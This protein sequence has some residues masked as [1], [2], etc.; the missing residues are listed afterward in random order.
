MSQENSAVHPIF[1]IFRIF[2]FIFALL[3]I[4]VLALPIGFYGMAMYIE[5]TLPNVDELKTMP[6]EMPLQIY[7]SDH[8]LIG[9]YGTRYSLPVT[10]GELPEPLI[11]A[12]LAAEDDTFFEHSGISV[13][14]LGRAIMQMM[15]HSS[16][17]TGGSSITQ[18]VAKNYFLT[19]EQTFERKL[20]EMYLARKIENE[21]TKDEIMTLY[22]N[23]IYLGQSAYGI[24]AGAR[25]Y[26]SKSLENLTI[27][28]MAMLAGLPK[29][30]SDFNPVINPDRALERRNWIIGRM[31]SEGFIDQ[32]QHDEAVSAPIGLNMYQERLDIN[33]P[34]VAEMTKDALVQKYGEAVM[35]SGWRV[36]LTIDSK[37]QLLAEEALQNGL[38]AYHRRHGSGWGGIAA[39]SGNLKN[40]L[41]IGTNIPA[42]VTAIH[43]RSIKVRLNSGDTVTVPW[44]G[45]SW[46]R[47]Y[48]NA[49]PVK[50]FANPS[51]MFEEGNI[52]YIEKTGNSWK[53]ANIPIVQ[54]ALAS[55]N[56]ENGAVI[57]VAGGFHFNQ[58]KFNR[59][60]Q[61]YRQPGS[62]IKPLVYAA[63]IESKKFTPDSMISDQ[64]LRVGSWKP[65]NAD[66]R[67]YGNLSMR[68]AIAVSRN[69][70]VIR[71]LNKTGIEETR[72]LMANMG[73]EKSQLP[74]SLA[75]ALGAAGATPLQM[76]TA[77]S[78]F[79][80]GGHRVQPYF[81]ERIY[82]FDS[83]TIYQASPAQACA[84]CFNDDLEK[85]NARL[86]ENFALK[87]DAVK[88]TDKDAK[89][90]NDDKSSERP[91]DGLA[92]IS[93]DLDATPL[94]DR[95]QPKKAPHYD[96]AVQAPRI[97]APSTA[98]DMSEMLRGV[99]R[100]GTGKRALALG[101][102]DV[103]GKT[104]TTNQAKDAWFAGVHPS[105]VAVVWVGFDEP[106][107]L[108]ASEYG[109]VAALP[110]WVEFMRGKLKDEPVR[111]ISDGNLTKSKS[112]TQKRKDAESTDD[113]PSDDTPPESDIPTDGDIPEGGGD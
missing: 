42:Q 91:Q 110:I 64:P 104:G 56:P 43:A 66:G 62:I 27:A 29:A 68:H 112:Q 71:V 21:M 73:L 111:W 67:F 82:D 44:S 99:I 47:L 69:L 39:K 113:S 53:L 54:G 86:A 107:S 103:G 46:A 45:M 84:T 8:K 25:R 88:V 48:K 36:L 93:A 30:P 89:P 14:G 92:K 49:R 50:S 77:Y 52:I 1:V 65:K 5:P 3:L 15:S 76:A 9:Q 74:E 101:R 13:K 100:G 33:L 79:I 16:D 105:T 94:H 17:Q 19:P 23:K 38:W 83:Q 28:E 61:G 106:S 102:S 12:F 80:N 87:A 75:L 58:S 20:T 98:Y 24:K 11:Q 95:L 63:G 109:G 31:L 59:A 2:G 37:D 90:S 72:A 4:C 32:S 34:Y 22:V 96:V 18:Q 81:I 70:P 35:Q 78:T 40:F 26:F 6:L 97:I 7:T 41:A 57:A 10:Y 55:M 108:G 85:Y 60:T 51:Q